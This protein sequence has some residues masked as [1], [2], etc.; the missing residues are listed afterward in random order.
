LGRAAVPVMLLAGLLWL[1]IAAPRPIVTLQLA[2]FD[3]LQRLQPRIY[4]P[5]P[6]RI[7]DL[8]D[9]TL[10]RFGQWPW[11]RTQLAELTRTLAELGAASIA[12]DIVFAEPDRTSPSVVLSLWPASSVL[13][14]LRAQVTALPSHDAL[15]AQT[16]ADTRTVVTGFALTSGTASRLPAVKAGFAFSGE[17]PQAM[18]GDFSGAVVNLAELES[19]AAGNGHFNPLPDP[20]G[21]IRRVPLLLRMGETL[22]PALVAEALRVAQGATTYIV[23]SSGGSGEANFGAKTGMTHL[24]IGSVILPTDGNGRVWL[25]D[26]G[27]V[28]ER[29][30][31]AWRVLEGRVAAPEVEGALLFIG[32]SA[33]GLKDIRATPLNP[34]AAGVEIHAQLAEQALLQ[35]FLH[36]PDW[37]TGAEVLLLALLGLALILLLP[38]VGAVWCAALAVGSALLVLWGSWHA[39]VAYRWLLDPVAPS[40][41]VLL[42]YLVSSFVHFLDTESERRQVRQAFGRYLSPELVERLARDPSRL[43]LGGEMRRMTILFA[44]IRGFTTI[45]ERLTAERLTAFMNRFLT[46]MTDIILTHRGFID[47]YIGDCIMAFWN[48]PLDDAEPDRHACEAALRMRSHLVVFNQQLRAEAKAQGEPFLPVHIGIGINTGECCVGNMGSEQRFDYSVLGDPVNVASRLEALSKTYGTDIVIGEETRRGAP[49][50][51]ALELDLITVKGK[52]KPATVH[53]LLGDAQFGH[54]AEFCALA[55]V[56]NRMLAAYRAQRWDEAQGLIEACVK[57]DTPKTRLRTFY[58]LY[59]QRMMMYRAHP[60]G[61]DWDGVFVAGSK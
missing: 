54:S 8:D 12:F 11:P 40:L 34:V 30:I 51:A 44:D 28:P 46:P 4:E 32:T 17:S 18:L 55:P 35:K 7:V 5:V 3:T 15:F 27:Y 56:H 48:A 19:D 59:T 22:Y 41:A 43:T 31:P 29:F 47:K 26:T 42:L 58:A 61:A 1:R 25:Y 2:A 53:G 36:R 16:I 23:K 45:A 14:P 49:E 60:P 33:T 13:E 37:A 24:K 20:D 6:V 57:R 39:Y 10:A 38:R 52:T 50:L 9:E 21:V